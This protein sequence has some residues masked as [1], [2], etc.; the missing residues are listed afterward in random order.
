MG[1]VILCIIIIICALVY[2][3]YFREPN[4]VL[5]KFNEPYMIDGMSLVNILLDLNE[6]IENDRDVQINLLFSGEKVDPLVPFNEYFSTMAQRVV[7]VEESVKQKTK[8]FNVLEL[9][10]RCSPNV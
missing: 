10:L 1:F 7:I 6:I 3:L 9:K 5:L 8:G 4:V 2:F